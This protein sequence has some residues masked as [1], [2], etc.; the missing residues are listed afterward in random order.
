MNSFTKILCPIDLSENSKSAIALASSLAKLSSAKLIFVHVGPPPLPREAMFAASDMEA[1]MARHQ[2]QLADINATETGVDVEH[3][4]LQGDAAEEVLKFAD[5]HMCDLIVLSTHG[6]TGIARLLM[7][8]VAEQIVRESKI[9]V[10]SV[11][12]PDGIVEESK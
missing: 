10:M 1:Y 3:V 2:E 9:P 6:R 8:S 11:R 4:V 12:Y 7:G 5:E